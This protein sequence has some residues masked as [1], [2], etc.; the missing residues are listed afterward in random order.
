MKQILRNLHLFI[1]KEKLIFAITIL[2]IFVSA[3]L[4]NFSYGLYQN[5]HVLKEETEIQETN[6][7]TS[8][9]RDTEGS[10]LK[11]EALCRY[12]DS[13]SPEVLNAVDII[14][15]TAKFPPLFEDPFSGG[16]KDFY[17]RFRI[18]NGNYGVS[19]ITKEAWESGGMIVSGRYITDEEEA[20]GANVAMVANFNGGGW[21]DNT[22]A[23]YNGDNTITMFGKTYEIIG[24]YSSGWDHP[25]I[26]F[27]SIP[28][29]SRIDTL[30]FVFAK[31]ITRSQYEELKTQADILLPN[32]LVFPEMSFPD[33][34]TR[35]LYNNIMLISV[36][37]AIL[38]ALNFAMLYQYILKKRSKTLAILRL[39]GCTSGRAMCIYLGECLLLSIP[40]YL[41]GTVTFDILMR[42]V[43]TNFFPYMESAYTNTIY[44]VIFLIYILIVLIVLSIMI[45]GH[46]HQ[47]ILEEWR[48]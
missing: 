23:I 34:D 38:S 46:I 22:K 44:S 18:Q 17:F 13:V 45:A 25:I 39:C 1:R 5:Y 8:V 28:D 12:L 33:P 43:L 41:L 19:L 42:N 21:S 40:T 35:Y 24:E 20:A 11:K 7:E 27:L 31:N 32:V 15:A 47:E 3:L 9:N 26:P 36:L 4:L 29:D 30:S 48:G 10:L 2:C 37:L 14:C 6:L 16:Y